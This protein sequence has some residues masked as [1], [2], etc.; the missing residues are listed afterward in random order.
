[1][2]EITIRYSKYCPTK[3]LCY[4]RSSTVTTQV[5]PTEVTA[6]KDIPSQFSEYIHLKP[7]VVYLCRFTNQLSKHYFEKSLNDFMQSDSY[8][9]FLLVLHIEG[10]SNKMYLYLNHLRIIIEQIESEVRR[11]RKLFV[12]LLLIP[13]VQLFTTNYPCLFLQG[14]DLHYLDSIS[15]SLST[16][17]CRSTIKISDWF[18]QLCI[19]DAT[20]SPAMTSDAFLV[21]LLDDII[22]V[23]V[24]RA[25]FGQSSNL[26]I[27]SPMV[28]F[29]RCQLIR[30]LLAVDIGKVLCIR[31]QGYW[32]RNTM[33]RY[34]Q[35]TAN[36]I[37]SHHSTLS[38][39]DQMQ[40]TLHFLF[41]NFVVFILNEINKC[42]GLDILFTTE[43]ESKSVVLALND[44]E[45]QFLLSLTSHM[46]KYIPVPDI[47]T[48]NM[49]DK[50]NDSDVMLKSLFE[51]S[52]CNFPLSHTIIRLFKTIVEHTRQVLYEQQKS[53]RVSISEQMIFERAKLQWKDAFKLQVCL[54]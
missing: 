31:F 22:P 47:S 4:T 11:M 6:L 39:A 19:P 50:D 48:I 54:Y 40:V 7:D 36:D 27:N 26:S 20:V 18:E 35:M 29:R 15:P 9:V 13:Q 12:V 49:Y 5:F 25:S 38:L 33:N 30:S 14:W 53:E 28:P 1:M 44:K 46:L 37:Y 23:V 16:S 32:N 45:G 52:H 34:L 17:R 24:S 21:D 2:L 8:E 42:Y 10:D 3:L 51:G 41:G 43:N